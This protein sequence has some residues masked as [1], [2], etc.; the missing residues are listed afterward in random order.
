MYGNPFSVDPSECEP[1]YQLELIDLQNCSYLKDVYREGNLVDFYKCLPKNDYPH[2]HNKALMFTSLFGSTYICEQTFKLL[3]LN[4][5]KFRNKLSDEN[6]SS[7]L[8]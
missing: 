2:L 1:E 6:F 5:S 3:T 7:V 8:K 4:K